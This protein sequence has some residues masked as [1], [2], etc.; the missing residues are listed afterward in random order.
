[1]QG[2]YNSM[3]LSLLYISLF[4]YY[5]MVHFYSFYISNYHFRAAFSLGYPLTWNLHTWGKY[6]EEKKWIF[7]TLDIPREK[8]PVVLS[9]SK[10]NTN[11]I[12][13]FVVR[14]HLLGGYYGEKTLDWKGQLHSVGPDLISQVLKWESSGQRLNEVDTFHFFL[15]ERIMCSITA[16]LQITWRSLEDSSP[17]KPSDENAV[18]P[19]PWS[20]PCETLSRGPS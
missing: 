14:S 8:G 6:A 19:T 20:Q 11:W 16:T 15:E 7:Q 18:W 12:S 17:V 1:M 2:M 3:F 13:G 10:E 5:D 4:L 9:L